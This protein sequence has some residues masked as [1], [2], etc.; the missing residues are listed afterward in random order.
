MKAE[1]MP[2]ASTDKVII[3]ALD[4]RKMFAMP[5]TT[6]RII[7]M[8]RNLPIEPRS[9]LI[10]D[11][12]MA[13]PKKMAPVPAKAVMIRLAPFVKPSTE[14]TNRDSIKPMKKVK[15]SSIG[16]PAAEFL[17]FSIAYMKPKAPTRKTIRPIPG[18]IARD[19]PLLTPIHAPSTVGTIDKASSQ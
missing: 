14:P 16:T 6:S 15:P 17:V 13:M 10:T 11:D 4:C 2:M 5:A 18:D 12:S 8:K 3:S 1:K 9:R 19:K 7:P